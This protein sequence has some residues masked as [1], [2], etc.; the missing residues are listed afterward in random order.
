MAAPRIAWATAISACSGCHA[1]GMRGLVLPLPRLPS[2]S[3]FDLAAIMES[4]G[5]R[6]G[7]RWR[8]YRGWFDG[9]VPTIRGESALALEERT[10]EPGGVDM[11]WAEIRRLAAACQQIID[12][13]FVGYD[14]AGQP[15]LRL[16]AVDSS[17][18]IIWSKDRND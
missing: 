14:D 8:L 4:L 5:D 3:W 6:S 16:L 18:W 15:R 10:R 12:G 1:D 9:A 7:L 11:T 17:Y 2:G 13:D